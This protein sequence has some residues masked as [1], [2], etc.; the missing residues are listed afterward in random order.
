[1]KTG[2]K[3]KAN[4]K[5]STE[6]IYNTLRQE[7]LTL[8]LAPGSVID[9][10]SLST[11]FNISRVPVREAL[12]R[13]AGSGL[14]VINRNKMSM[15]APLNISD[16]PKYIEALDL[17]QRAVTALAARL[18]SAEDLKNIKSCMENFD[19]AVTKPTDYMGISE[20]NKKFHIAI[21]NA[22]KNP[23]LTDCYK[24]LLDE[25]QRFLH[26]QFDH[27]VK[28]D[29]GEFPPDEHP[30]MYSAIEKQDV[31]EAEDMA[32]AHTMQFRDRFLSF[33]QQNHTEDFN[34]DV[35][36]D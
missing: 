21:A 19:K 14:V 15:V 26:I 22:G 36:Q 1:M 24:N 25:G 13:L 35:L 28:S 2:T 6:D 30:L 27:H 10:V 33:L 5:S 18:R 23:Y 11:R 12:K 7:I 9:E 29:L 32:H 34:I 17:I 8:K 16:F 31:K 4:N 20:S 3:K